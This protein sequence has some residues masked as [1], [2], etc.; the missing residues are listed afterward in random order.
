[1]KNKINIG[2]VGC[3]AHAQIAHLPAFKKNVDC[4]LIAICDSD[5]RKIDYLGSKYSIPYRYQDFPELLKNSEIDALVISTPNYLHAP[6]AISALEYGKHVLCDIPMAT[7]LKEAQDVVK[8]AR[9]AKGRLAM[10]LSDRFR[11]DVQTLKKFIKEGELGEI[12]YVKTGWL[13]GSKNWILNPWRQEYLKSGGGAFL[14]LG[15]SLVDLATYLLEDKRMS[16]IFA[17][18]HKKNPA[19]NVE[20]TAMCII[21][22]ADGTLLTVEV[23]WS[24]IFD[25]DFL[26]CNIFGKKGAALLNPLKIQKELHNELVNVAPTF[27]QKNLYKVSYELQAQFFIDSLRK[28]AN[29]PFGYEDGLAI[30]RITDA[31]YESARKHKLIKI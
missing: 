31:F 15:V 17:S 1:M 7:S 24:L 12:Y 26:Y 30:A 14:S 16:T 11:P 2:I 28:N 3:G 8:V 23:S 4:N 18:I 27:P 21:N 6:M 10:A 9:K 29:P 25:R 5:A 20:D 13:I 22:Y 19:A